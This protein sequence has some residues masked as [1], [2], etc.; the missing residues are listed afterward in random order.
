MATCAW[1]MTSKNLYSQILW[2]FNFSYK[3]DNILDLGFHIICVWKQYQYT[4]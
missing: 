1:K 2:Y 3:T 4:L